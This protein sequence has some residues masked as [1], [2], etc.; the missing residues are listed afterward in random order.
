MGVVSVMAT[1]AGFFEDPIKEHCG[2]LFQYN[3]N[4][5]N[6][7]DRIGDLDAK[8]DGVQ[9]KIDAAKRNGQVILPV[10]ERR[11]EKARNKLVEARN[12]LNEDAEA[13][14]NGSGGWC[15]RYS[16]SM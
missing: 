6:L 14:R 4:I 5:K 15:T 16:L 13:N 2:Y 7:E 11:V 3:S 9:L 12:I 1:I 8:I 10:V